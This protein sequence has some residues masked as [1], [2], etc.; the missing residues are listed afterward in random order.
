M[1]R[2][3]IIGAL[4]FFT[5]LLNGKIADAHP[6]YIS[7]CEINYNEK[8]RA[9]EISVKIFTDDLEAGVAARFSGLALKL[10]TPKELTDSDD[11]IAKYI[12]EKISLNADGKTLVFRY[13]GR[14][15]EDDAQWIHFEASNL[16]A[17]HKITIDNRI[18]LDKL[19]GQLNITHIKIGKSKQSCRQYKESEPCLFEF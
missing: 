15:A 5:V 12:K 18:L 8:S 11:Y 17:P 16:P 13:V 4:I 10:E 2:K 7:M 14:E 3:Y 6:I 19:P 1:R 9:Y